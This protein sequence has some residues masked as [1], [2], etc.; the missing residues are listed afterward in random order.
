MKKMRVYHD[1]T[2]YIDD[3]RTAVYPSIKPTKEYTLDHLTE[4]EFK[5]L[6][7][8]PTDKKLMDKVV[9]GQKKE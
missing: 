5:E 9:K 1:G 8:N 6:K 3:G 4:E 7:K 2:V